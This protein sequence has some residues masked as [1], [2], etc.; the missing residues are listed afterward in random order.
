M[1][2]QNKVVEREQSVGVNNDPPVFSYQNADLLTWEFC[3]SSQADFC[4]WWTNYFILIT[5]QLI[6]CG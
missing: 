3:F 1:R 6:L 4:V 5:K 2:R